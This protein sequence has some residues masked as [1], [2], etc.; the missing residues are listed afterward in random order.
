MEWAF[1]GGEHTYGLRIVAGLRDFWFY[2]SHIFEMRRYTGLALDH[3]DVADAELR[4]GVLM[5][6]AFLYYSELDRRSVDHFEQA[7]DLYESIGDRKHQALA[8]VFVSGSRKVFDND[9]DAAREGFQRGLAMARE[10]GAREV[11][12]Q[13][14]NYLGEIER[15]VGNYE[16]ALEIQTECLEL[17]RSTGEVR[18]VAMVSHNLGWIAHHLG[19]DRLAAQRFREALDAGV[20]YDFVIQIAESLFGLAEQLALGDDLESAAQVIGFAQHQY[21]RMGAR[22][23][24]ADAADQERVRNLVSD[25]LGEHDFHVL[26]EQG[27]KLEL[28]EA[29]ELVGD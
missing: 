29:I 27:T 2:Q 9:L 13:A 17:S 21:D 15:Y 19:D 26:S 20:E 24:L 28:I 22:A 18:R 12:A 3:L 6:A 1:H 10:S 23:Q 8:V 14:L 25:R 4:A 11:I 5:T 7:A 16:R